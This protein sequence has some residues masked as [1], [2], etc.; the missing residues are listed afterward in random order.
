MQEHTGKA[1][2]LDAKSRKVRQVYEAASASSIGLELGLAVVIGWA[3]GHWI[4]GKAGT[5]PLFMIIFLLLGIA[6]GFKGVLRVA[7]QA[8]RDDLESNPPETTDT[9]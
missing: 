4:D 6:A 2:I 7:R 3:M 1:P 9:K 8:K 5:D